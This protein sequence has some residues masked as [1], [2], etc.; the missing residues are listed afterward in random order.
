[1]FFKMFKNDKKDKVSGKIAYFNLE[2]WWLNEFSPEERDIIRNTFKSM[3]TEKG[4]Y[5]I[6]KGNITSSS[7]SKLSFLGNLANWFSKNEYY[8]IAKKIILEAEKNLDENKSILDKHF[9]YLDC[10]KLFYSNRDYYNDALDLAIEY[11]K[12]QICISKQAKNQF[13]KE[14]PNS[15]L[16]SHTG[17]KQLAIIYEKDKRY[18]EALMITRQAFSEGWN[19]QSEKR[20]ER[21][22]NKLKKLK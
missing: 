8:P 5:Y 16:P 2:E 10:I 20:I 11:C 18:D 21:L 13:L 15:E 9:F 1:M 17:F 4:N 12:K 3:N 6:D 22:E 7:E 19:N 14:Y